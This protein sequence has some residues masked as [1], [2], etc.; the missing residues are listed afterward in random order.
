MAKQPFKR[1]D[2]LLFAVSRTEAVALRVG[3]GDGDDTCVVMTRW[4]GDAS[5]TWSQLKS[6][7]RV[8]ELKAVT[9]H[10]KRRPLLGAWVSGAPPASMRKLGTA[11][12]TLPEV[13]HPRDYVHAPEGKGAQ[14][15]PRLSWK[16]FL[17]EVRLQWRWDVDR[18]ALLEEESAREA[19]GLSA[20][21]AALRGGAR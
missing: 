11:R 14:V 12:L 15:L 21:Q 13:V 20:L 1:G 4:E 9:H 7:A 2:V 18:E 19:A 8:G 16:T 3:P 6:D 5:A 10:D 17:E